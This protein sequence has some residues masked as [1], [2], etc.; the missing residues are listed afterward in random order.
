[1]ACTRLYRLHFMKIFIFE[2]NHPRYNIEANLPL[3]KRESLPRTALFT[4]PDT[5]LLTRGRPLFVPD[6]A[7][8]CTIQAHLVVRISR[9]GRHV[10]PRFARRYYDA[11]TVGTTCTA[12]ALFEH[13]HRRGLPWELSKAFDGA[14]S[15]GTWQPVDEE[16][17]PD[18]VQVS[19]HINGQS[20]QR[21]RTAELLQKVDE[22]IA[23]VSCFYKL[24]Q[25]DLLFTGT[26]SAGTEVHID[27]PI[28]GFA[29]GRRLL[30]YNI[31]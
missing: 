30:S 18:D 20:V 14:A 10:S 2:G 3:C 4:L 12:H 7:W 9:L 27:D 23:A 17:A 16:H 31:K 5:A 25:G 24:C 11:F 13:L 21:F 26:D 29:N 1:M 22:Q 8:P 15:I 6:E 28:E 19:L